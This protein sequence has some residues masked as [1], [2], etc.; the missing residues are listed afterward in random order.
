MNVWK[1]SIQNIKSKPLYTFLSVF[2]LALSVTLLIG[3][4]QLKYSFQYQMEHNLGTIDMVVGAKGS[5]LQLVLSSVL[6]VDNPTGNISYNEA[7]RLS[8]NKW[9][10]SA[11]PISYGDNYKGY[12]IVGTTAAFA[13]LYQA[14]L[15][16]GKLPSRPMEVVVGS[17]VAKKLGLKIGDS[18]LSSHGLL[19]NDFDIHEEEFHVVGVYYPTQKVLDRLIVT[20]LESV[21]EVHDH[22][23][24]KEHEVHEE[25]KEHE[26][27]EEHKE[28]KEHEVHEGQHIEHHK[29]EK[30]ITSLLVS[31]RGPTAFLS[32]PRMI[33]KNT[34]MQAALPKL[35]LDKLYEFTGL[36]F[37]TISWIAYVVLVISG[38]LIFT[39]LYK[40]VKERAFDLALLRTY[41]ASNFQLIK[42][43]AYEGLV[44][45]FVGVLL[46]AVL[47]K[48]GLTII[49]QLMEGSHPNFAIQ[50]LPINQILPI[51]ILLLAMLILAL[52][53]AIFPI[54]KMNVSTILS[55]EK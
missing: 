32:L 1:I 40:M 30:E 4:Q 6:H 17:F 14:K 19:E 41:G 51:L 36:G 5:P 25:H 13:N 12:R 29:E 33:N 3:V 45:V 48:L 18:F 28:H 46:G 7:M 38:L 16:E 42:M 31:F 21:W 26:V 35:E 39:S 44:I 23:E 47:A 55:N 27:H 24:H 50:N 9:I 53:L 2:V 8:K 15:Q 10:T 34:N 49:L 22:E 20:T 54:V 43:M 11:V 52:S 37:Q